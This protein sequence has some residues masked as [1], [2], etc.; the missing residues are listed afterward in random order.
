MRRARRYTGALLLALALAA[1]SAA[2]AAST[3]DL[4][5]C[6]GIAD[7]GARLA[8]YDALLP[9]AAVAPAPPAA[10]VAP[11]APVAAAAVVHAAD[12]FGAE[13]VKKSKTADKA[14]DNTLH[15]RIVGHIETSKKGTRFKLD[16]GQVWQDVDDRERLLDVDDAAVTIERNFIGSYFMT[17]DGDSARIRV[18]RIQ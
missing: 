13:S 14:E 10:A 2:Q 4:Q 8:C 11:A 7:D 9:A 1:T 6:R 16:N 15:A 5:R 17:L 18:R 3:A 12:D